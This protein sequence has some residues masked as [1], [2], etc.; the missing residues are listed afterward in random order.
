MNTDGGIKALDEG[1]CG[2]PLAPMFMGPRNT[3]EDDGEVK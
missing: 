3:C 2:A 1:S